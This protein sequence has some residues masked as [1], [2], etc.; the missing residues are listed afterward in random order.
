MPSSAR[1]FVLLRHNTPVAVHWDLMLDTGPELATWQIHEDP[2]TWAERPAPWTTDATRIAGHR[3]A[4]L[5][6]EG[7]VSRNRGSVIR[8]DRGTFITLSQDHHRWEIRFSGSML[9]GRCCLALR[10]GDPTSGTWI[11]Q[12]LA[13]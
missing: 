2:L 9:R 4:Y 13:D 1:Q 8:V 11:L 12:R 5:D 7:P 3:R 6:Y 10:D